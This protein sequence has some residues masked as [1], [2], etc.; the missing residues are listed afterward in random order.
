[1][2]EDRVEGLLQ[3]QTSILETLEIYG[4]L[5]DRQLE[6]LQKLQED[7][8]RVH[9]LIYKLYVIHYPPRQLM[10]KMTAQQIIDSLRG[11][12]NSSCTCM[13][14]KSRSNTFCT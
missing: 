12:L 10:S 6:Q 9:H 3:V 7:V 4:K 13:R 1:M 5:Y 14:I 11:I 8:A 2:T